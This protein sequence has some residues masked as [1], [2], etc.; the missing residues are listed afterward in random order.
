[1][2]FSVAFIESTPKSYVEKYSKLIRQS[3]SFVDKLPEYY[4]VSAFEHPKLPIVTSERIVWSQW[5]LIPYWVKSPDQARLIK[6]KTLNATCENIF[7]KPSF[8]KSILSKRCIL[9][10]SGFFEWRLVKERKIP[11]YIYAAKKDWLSIGCIYDEWLNE[12]TGE[13][14]NT[15][16]I[17]TTPANELL[18]KIHNTKQRMPLILSSDKENFWLDDTLSRKDLIELM[19][20]NTTME[21][22]AYPVSTFLNYSRNYRNTPEAIKRQEYNEINND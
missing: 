8:K 12:S 3:N 5:G 18:S 14:I 9:G 13:L 15:F 1:M 17:V 4:F 16:S 11:Y 10:V 6:T 7:D 21:L 20:P 2:C 22:E 19:I